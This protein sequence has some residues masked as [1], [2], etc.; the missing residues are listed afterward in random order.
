MTLDMSLLTP[1]AA[2]SAGASRGPAPMSFSLR[3]RRAGCERSAGCF[4]LGFRSRHE[5]VGGERRVRADHVVG[6]EEL[7]IFLEAR[8]DA[9]VRLLDV[10]EQRTRTRGRSPSAMVSVEGTMPPTVAT[11]SL[12]ALF[13]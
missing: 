2:G 6:Q 8:D 9:Q 10:E 1:E 7:D 13:S 4:A 5:A 11:F 12:S 3:H